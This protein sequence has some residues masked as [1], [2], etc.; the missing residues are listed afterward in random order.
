MG[1]TLHRGRTFIW[2]GDG[3]GCKRRSE[4]GW[5]WVKGTEVERYREMPGWKKTELK[6]PAFLPQGIASVFCEIS[7]TPSTPC[8]R[9]YRHAHQLSG[10]LHFHINS[11]HFDFC[12]VF[13]LCLLSFYVLALSV[14]R[15]HC[16]SFSSAVGCWIIV[17]DYRCTGEE[18]QSEIPE[19]RT[20][21]LWD[22]LRGPA[23]RPNTCGA[24]Q[25]ETR[26]SSRFTVCFVAAGMTHGRS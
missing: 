3:T 14:Q 20:A 8:L 9:K 25:R 13:L 11:E 18:L 22:Q 17:C 26:R 19:A 23:V 2:W 15:V 12:F 7:E 5:G 6:L 1:E 10:C 16:V 21:S 24:G 4:F